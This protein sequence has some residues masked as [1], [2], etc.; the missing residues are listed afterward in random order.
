MNNWNYR[1]IKLSED[2]KIFYSITEAYYDDDGEIRAI[3]ASPASP[4]GEDIKELA[5][6]VMMMAGALSLPIID[7]TEV[8]YVQDAPET[9]H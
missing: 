1:V 6:D 7:S 8:Q 2:G 9:T 4:M 3:T 5:E